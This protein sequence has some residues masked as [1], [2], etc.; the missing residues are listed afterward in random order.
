[1]RNYVRQIRIAV[2][3][4][5][6]IQRVSCCTR[7]RSRAAAMDDPPV[8]DRL[9]RQH[10]STPS[11]C[12][13]H[14]IHCNILWGVM[15]RIMAVQHFMYILHWNVMAHA[16]KPDFVFRR[17][18]RIHLNRQGRQFSRLLAV[19]VCA[20]AVIMLDTPC[21]E[22]VWRV[23]TTHSIRQFP[24]HLLS[25]ASPCA[26]TFQL[27]STKGL[28]QVRGL[29]EWFVTWYVEELTPRTTPKMEDHPL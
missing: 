7:E 19:E 1:M 15:L 9:S 3:S 6:N 4:L 20:S 5:Y 16:Q 25:C 29:S 11:C 13:A 10:M 23:L 12:A 21:S 28:V 24:L 18:G 26:I 22:V 2:S 14:K 8:K 17:N 27:D